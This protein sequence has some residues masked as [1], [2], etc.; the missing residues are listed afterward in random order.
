MISYTKEIL[1]EY[2]KND[3]I[4]ELIK[5]NINKYSNE[6]RKRTN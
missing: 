4:L 6:R 2:L 1:N 3:W 5:K